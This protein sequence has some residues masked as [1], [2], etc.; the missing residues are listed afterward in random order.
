MLKKIAYTALIIFVLTIVGDFLKTYIGEFGVIVYFTVMQLTPILF[1]SEDLKTCLLFGLLSGA[2][3]GMVETV[4]NDGYSPEFVV[5]NM[6]TGTVLGASYFPFV[7]SKN[8]MFLAFLFLGIFASI[9]LHYFVDFYGG[10]FF[11]GLWSMFYIFQ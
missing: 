10:D 3:F 4:L 6:I 5:L 1:F 11:L 8:I 7:K 9:G 2:M